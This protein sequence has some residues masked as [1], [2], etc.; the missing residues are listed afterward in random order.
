MG[1]YSTVRYSLLL[2]C[3]LG[4]TDVNTGHCIIIRIIGGYIPA[5]DFCMITKNTPHM[6]IMSTL[7]SLF[8]HTSPNSV[9]DDYVRL[10][11]F[12]HVWKGVHFGSFSE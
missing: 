1:S 9:R 10:H 12:S 3:T 2:V 5:G 7:A 6:A 4:S 8:V 11:S